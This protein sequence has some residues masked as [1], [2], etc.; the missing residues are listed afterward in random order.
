MTLLRF[1]SNPIPHALICYA[2]Q[3]LDKTKRLCDYTFAND[4]QSG[5]LGQNTNLVFVRRQSGGTPTRVHC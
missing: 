2:G 4:R 3:E 1:N 5:M